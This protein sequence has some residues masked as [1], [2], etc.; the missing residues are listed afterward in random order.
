MDR[1][2]WPSGS[3]LLAQHNGSDAC[4]LS[5]SSEFNSCSIWLPV[6]SNILESLSVTCVCKWVSPRLSPVS[7]T[8]TL[9]AV[10]KTILFNE[11]NDKHVWPQTGALDQKRA[12]PCG[13]SRWIV[14]RSGNAWPI[15]QPRGFIFLEE[16][17]I[18]DIH[19]K[20]CF[21]WSH[22][23][24]RTVIPSSFT[25]LFSLIPSDVNCAVNILSV[26]LV[27]ILEVYLL[28]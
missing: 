24:V 27:T 10:K 9:S 15:N 11:R 1:S 17:L 23:N 2:S 14:L 12:C 7:P 21:H 18:I 28:K 22:V 5:S 13:V 3:N 8:V 20:T 16:R 25:P 4:N 26:N 19:L 6:K